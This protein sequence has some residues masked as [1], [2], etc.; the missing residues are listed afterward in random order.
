MTDV[1]G[2]GDRGE[3]RA[4]LDDFAE[5]VRAFRER[6]AGAGHARRVLS[7]PLDR[8]AWEG[9]GEEADER[10]VEMTPSVGEVLRT[11]G[12]P[13][14]ALGW[15]DAALDPSEIMT[16]ATQEGSPVWITAMARLIEIIL[17]MGATR[18]ALPSTDPRTEEGLVCLERASVMA[19]DL[20]RQHR[21]YEPL[22]AVTLRHL[23][24]SH[25]FRDEE[26]EAGSYLHPL[27]GLL[28]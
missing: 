25:A 27:V 7:F 4:K 15:Y 5:A 1:D 16:D 19:G 21:E 20:A 11:L 2:G 12:R 17:G 10:L 23:G 18:V 8:E 28:E 3:R 14:E 13:E 22:L 26:A 6:P 24:M 9:L